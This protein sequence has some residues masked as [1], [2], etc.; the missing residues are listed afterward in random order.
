MPELPE[1]RPWPGARAVFGSDAWALALLGILTALTLIRVLWADFLSYDDPFYV[2][3]NSLV[4]GGWSFSSL[5]RAWTTF[6]CANWHPATWMSLMLDHQLYGLRPWGFHLTNLVLHVAN[7]LLLYILLRRLSLT[8][9]P[10]LFISAVFGVHPLH[11]ESVA[12]VTERKDVL[13]AFFGLLALLAYVRGVQTGDRWRRFASIGWF[14]LSLSSKALLVTLPCLLVLLDCWPLRRLRNE[15]GSRIRENSDAQLGP[16]PQ[17]H[18]FRYDGVQQTS[19]LRL[20]LEKW[21]FWLLSVG[22]SVL[23][24]IAQHEGGAVASLQRFTFTERL[25]NVCVSYCTYVQKSVWPVRLAVYYP[26]SLNR[27]NAAWVALAVVFLIAITLLAWRVRRRHGGILLGWLWFVG[28]LVPMIGLVQVGSQAMADRYMYF[29]LIGLTWAVTATVLACWPSLCDIAGRTRLLPSNEGSGVELSV[30]KDEMDQSPL[31]PALEKRTGRGQGSGVRGNLASSEP[32]HPLP[33]SPD[34]RGEGSQSRA[35]IAAYV[36]KSPASTWPLSVLATLIVAVL[37]GL[38]WQQTGH[39]QNS[40][41]LSQHTIQVTPDN[42]VAHEMHARALR[43]AGLNAEAIA[44]YRRAIAINPDY[45][46]AR[47]DLGLLLAQ[48][49]KLS[50]AIKQ[51]QSGLKT[52]PRNSRLRWNLANALAKQRRFDAADAEFRLA[53]TFAPDNDALILDHA[54]MLQQAGRFRDALAHYEQAVKR[55]PDSLVNQLELAVALSRVPQNQ[56]RD[57]VRSISLLEQL[58]AQTEAPRAWI[59]LAETQAA[60]GRTAKAQAAWERAIQRAI[61][62]QRPDLAKLARDSQKRHDKP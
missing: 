61:S 17:S 22:S 59:T 21:P 13:A 53:E 28:T 15:P 36:P 4:Q 58:C 52:V 5:I 40:L 27:W 26:Y 23:T 42:Y 11:V 49:D 24:V 34:Y 31:A 8:W 45:Y 20:V 62:L 57:L 35:E 1:R 3:N 25:S 44:E 54:R 9:G 6:E 12:W 30:P 41:S 50:D 51:F 47:N 29:S 14:A 18:D 39:W 60:A 38:T 33:L 37:C 46:S 48:Q 10:A 7:T 19:F 43:I 2:T 56:G 32:P 16:D 55:D